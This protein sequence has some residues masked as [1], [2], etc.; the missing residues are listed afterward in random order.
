MLITEQ[1]QISAAT[2]A[3]FVKQLGNVEFYCAFGNIQLGRNLFVRDIFEQ[4]IQNFAFPAAQ[5][6]VVVRF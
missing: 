3:E 1:D 5:L 4:G 2:Y 6:G